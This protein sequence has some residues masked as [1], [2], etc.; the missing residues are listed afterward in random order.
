MVK[1][2]TSLD[3]RNDI[4]SAAVEVFAE[5]GYYRATTAQVAERAAISQPYVYRFF[6]KESLLVAALDLSWQRI[7]HTFQ[8][9]RDTKAPEFLE[10]GFTRAYE[11][12][13]ESHRYEI[14]L[15][16]QA[17]TI[18]ET[19]VRETMTKGMN[20]VQQLVF[21]A[22]LQAG[23]EEPQERTTIFLARGMLCNVSM[24]LDMP[25]LMI[26]R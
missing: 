6:T 13:M 15:Q 2:T 18:L 24:A 19:P 7:L 17:M 9:V 25:N 22:F 21:N 12:I 1:G 20:D 5:L 11:K 8:L 4:I 23:I 10:E 3:R 26:K 16:M 14:L